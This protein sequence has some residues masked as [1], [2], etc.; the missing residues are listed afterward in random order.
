MEP[1]GGGR[2]IA[3]P[4]AVLA[5][6]K[7]VVDRGGSAHLRLEAA[8]SPQGEEIAPSQVEATSGVVMARLR[9]VASCASQDDMGVLKGRS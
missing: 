4:L 3:A 8:P 2:E 6:T 9:S 5:M 7:R 1:F